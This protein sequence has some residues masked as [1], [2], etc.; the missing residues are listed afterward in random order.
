MHSVCMPALITFSSHTHLLITCSFDHHVLITCCVQRQNW[1]SVCSDCNEVTEEEACRRDKV[2]EVLYT[3]VKYFISQLQPVKVVSSGRH[4]LI[5]SL[6]TNHAWSAAVLVTTADRHFIQHTCKHT[7]RHW[8]YNKHTTSDNPLLHTHTASDDRTCTHQ[9]SSSLP[10]C[11]HQQPPP[12][13]TPA[14]LF[15]YTGTF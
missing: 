14:L 4:G 11:K 3:E 10:M 7:T 12:P 2:W 1:R 9:Q 13:P 8:I 5:M 6:Y 15:R